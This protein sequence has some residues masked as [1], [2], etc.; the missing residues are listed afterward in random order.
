VELS[1]AHETAFRLLRAFEENTLNNDPAHERLQRVSNANQIL[2]RALLKLKNSY[3]QTRR[4]N[5]LLVKQMQRE[6]NA[7][8]EAESRCETLQYHLSLALPKTSPDI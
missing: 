5:V 8:H 2:Y 3:D 7:R 6:K 4:Q 1:A